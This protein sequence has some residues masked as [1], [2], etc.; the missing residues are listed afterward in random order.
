MVNDIKKR[1]E[2]V[3]KLS[4]FLDISMLEANKIMVS[5]DKAPKYVMR[6]N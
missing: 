1:V 2:V 6:S 3:F 4:R 5:M